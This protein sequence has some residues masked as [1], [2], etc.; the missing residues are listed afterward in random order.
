MFA[1]GILGFYY[2][3]KVTKPKSEDL[4]FNLTE[5]DLGQV[6]EPQFLA[7]AKWELIKPHSAHVSGPERASRKEM[8][9]KSPQMI[10]FAVSMR[11]CVATSHRSQGLLRP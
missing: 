6:T 9:E 1:A 11:M 10:K 4:G 3:E 8:F 7:F 5:G 2:H